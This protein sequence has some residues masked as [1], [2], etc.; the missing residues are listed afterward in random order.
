MKLGVCTGS[1][2]FQTAACLGFDYVEFSLSAM[3]AMNE[4]EFLA[5]KDTV[6]SC[7]I[8]LYS[9]NGMMPG[10]IPCVGPNASD[11]AV[12][13]YLEHA[14][15]RARQ[16]GVKTVVFGSG[17]SRG[18]PE[19][20]PHAQAWRQI[21]RFLTLAGAAGEKHGISIAIEPLRRAECNIVNYVS[22]AT[23]L[24]SV[25]NL[26]GVGVLGD[27]FHMNSV[28]EPY[29]ALAHAGNLL[30][31]V[32]ISHSP[33]RTYPYQHDGED[34]AALFSVLKNIGYEGG[35][36]IEAKTDDFTN[37]AAAALACLRA[38]MQDS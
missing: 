36:S 17:A 19:G 37:E 10:S 14:F 27:T 23:L 35:I 18:V 5:L 3:A 20:W 32:H 15:G 31:H 38:A 7:P 21:V 11:D 12:E 9:C 33:E 16:L 34:Y 13:A 2:N 29:E 6:A 30:R 26:P 4:E 8:P 24:A 1:E 22:E 28:G 25:V